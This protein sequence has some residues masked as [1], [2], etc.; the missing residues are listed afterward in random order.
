M[1]V[2]KL[3]TTG[4]H[5]LLKAGL[6][7]REQCFRQLAASRGMTVHGYYLVEVANGMSSYWPKSKT[8][9]EARNR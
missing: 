2:G 1:I 7:A 3:S 9:R 4:G 5:G 6:V 8:H